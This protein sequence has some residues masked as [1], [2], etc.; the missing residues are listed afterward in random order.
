MQ[1][2]N[3]AMFQR[4]LQPLRQVSVIRR[5]A[6]GA[7]SADRSQTTIHL[8]CYPSACLGLG[9]TI[10]T[11]GGDVAADDYFQGMFDTALGEGQIVTG[12][13]FPTPAKANYQKFVQT[14]VTVCAGRRLCQPDGGWLCPCR[15]YRRI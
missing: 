10:H 4:L 15:G 11:S 8:P 7:P 3:P 2:A 14:S 13:T 5:F 1:L 9:A 6:T 12:V